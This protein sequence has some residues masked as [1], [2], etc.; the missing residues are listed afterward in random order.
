LKGTSLFASR[1]TYLCVKLLKAEEPLSCIVYLVAI[2]IHDGCQ[3]RRPSGDVRWPHIA[4][5]LGRCFQ[6]GPKHYPGRWAAT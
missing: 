4:A 2:P 1:L 5:E 6:Q 3:L